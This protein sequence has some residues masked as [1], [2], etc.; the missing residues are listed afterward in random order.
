MSFS[1]SVVAYVPLEKLFPT[2]VFPGNHLHCMVGYWEPS[3]KQPIGL[4][5]TRYIKY[6]KSCSLVGVYKTNKLTVHVE[7]KK[8]LS[9]SDTLARARPFVR[10]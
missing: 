5:R 8:L 1:E 2:R 6:T 10:L 9:G 7:P 4:R 3:S